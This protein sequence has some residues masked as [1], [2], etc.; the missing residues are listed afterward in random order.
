MLV[1]GEGVR[2]HFAQVGGNASDSQI[3]FAQLV[4][5]VGVL[6]P[7]Y[8]HLL[9]VAVMGLHELHGLHKHT[10]GA[11]ARVIQDTV[12]RFNHLSN[13][14]NNTLWGIKFAL[15][16]AFRQRK[17]AQKV[18]V[19][20]ADNVI[21]CIAGVDLV[22]FIQ[23]RRQLCRVDVEPRIVVIRQSTLQRGIGLFN[24]IQRS[25]NFQ[26]NIILLGVL[27][28]IGPPTDLRQK[29]YI[30]LGIESDIV[31]ELFPVFFRNQFALGLKFV[32]CKF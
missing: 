3:H 15:T 18:F 22:D 6:L 8:G 9:F 11:A 25:V 27:H 10:A 23:Q 20:P 26:S 24:R 2:R 17:F 4:G 32:A 13:Q 5:G 31:Q 12:I 30:V 28:D 29:E 16:L 14:I 7:V 1:V 19:N 21:F